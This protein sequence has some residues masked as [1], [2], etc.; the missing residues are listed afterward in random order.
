MKALIAKWTDP[1]DAI[2]R[3]PSV[4]QWEDGSP[5]TLDD[6]NARIDD[7]HIIIHR[8]QGVELRMFPDIVAEV[9]YD[10]MT[11]VWGVTGLGIPPFA[12]SLTDRDATDFQILGELYEFPIVYRVRIHR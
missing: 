6:Y 4:I 7:T 11:G 3:D 12:L 10:S 2:H 1:E 9:R 8:P 5:A